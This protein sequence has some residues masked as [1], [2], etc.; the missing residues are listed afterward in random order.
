MIWNNI[1]L[2]ATQM[3]ELDTAASS[4]GVSERQLMENAG[5]ALYREISAAVPSGDITVVCGVGNNGGDGYA[6]AALLKQAGRNVTVVYTDAPKGGSSRYFLDLYIKNGGTL[7]RYADNAERCAGLIIDRSAAVVDA[8]F[9]F[10]FRGQLQGDYLK[11]TEIIN[12]THAKIV[13]ADL[14]SGVY[15]DGGYAPGCVSADITCTF[16][17]NKL[18]TLSYPSCAFC[19]RTVLCDIGVPFEVMEGIRPSGNVLNDSILSYA[20]KRPANSNKGTFGTL[21]ALCGSPDMPGAAYLASMGALRSGVGLLELMSDKDTLMILKHRLSEPVFAESSAYD[22]P[23]RPYNAFLVGCGIGRMYDDVLGDILKQQKHT[24]VIDADG[25][26]YIASHINVLT[27]MQGDIILTP[28]PGE[29]ARLMGATV[30]YVNENRTEC[31]RSFAMEFGCVLVL[32]GNRTVVASPQGQLSICTAGCSALAKGGSGDVLA[33]VI[34]SLAA[35][36]VPPYRAACLGVYAHA[37]A[38][39]ILAAEWGERGVLPHDLPREIG[40]LLG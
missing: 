21:L 17:V 20:Q 27:E 37:M 4:Y 1:Y 14:P 11:I 30:E 12:S 16:S 26:N 15:A 38:G 5:E 35:Q 10:S 2:T 7:L 22:K 19:G 39:D 9:G 3:K 29:M 23:P 25:I 8:L 13:S 24:T 40:R 32:K 33:G 31:A 28:H 34:A 6:V 18:S 36:G